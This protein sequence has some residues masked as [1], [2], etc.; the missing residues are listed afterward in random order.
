LHFNKDIRIMHSYVTNWMKI[1][2]PN[3]KETIDVSSKIAAVVRKLSLPYIPP[4]DN[5][6]IQNKP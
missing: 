4:L 5:T 2:G 1:Y 3:S 6:V